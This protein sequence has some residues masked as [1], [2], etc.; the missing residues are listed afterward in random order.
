MRS[1]Y[2]IELMLAIVGIIAAGA[3]FFYENPNATITGYVS[4]LNITIYVQNLDLYADGTQIYSLASTTSNLNLKY[5]SLDGEVVG[6]GRVEIFI[7]NGAGS[8][9]LIYENVVKTINYSQRRS[10]ITGM[11]VDEDTSAITGNAVG[12]NPLN[13]VEGT[14]LIIQPKKTS[15]PYEFRELESNEQKV[16]GTFHTRCMETCNIPSGTFN[17]DKYELLF[18][19]EKGT[20]VQ[21]KQLEYVL[22]ENG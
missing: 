1:I 12:E 6:D 21:V 15:I 9:Y 14:W 2:K 10:P 4:A 7:D 13:K 19:V 17:S 18:R 5:L 16:N 8:Q 20:H 3:M 11:I 22:H